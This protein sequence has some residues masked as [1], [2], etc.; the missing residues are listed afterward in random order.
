[1]VGRFSS[2]KLA[3]S[4]TLP[5]ELATGKTLIG[6]ER[7]ALESLAHTLTPMVYEDIADAYIEGGITRAAWVAPLVFF[8][9]SVST[10]E[11]TMNNLEKAG[12]LNSEEIKNI[13]E[14]ATE[15]A[16]LKKDALEGIVDATDYRKANEELKKMRE[17]SNDWQQ[18]K[19]FLTEQNKETK[20]SLGIDENSGKDRNKKKNRDSV[21]HNR[22][23]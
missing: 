12:L 17:N 13:K 19:D 11:K 2:Y 1:M 16:K 4:I 23:K 6:E 9:M 20:R 3:P 18:Y 10:Y 22:K 5:L 7:T 8:G 21:V 15:V 14:K